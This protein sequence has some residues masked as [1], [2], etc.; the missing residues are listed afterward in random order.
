MPIFRIS[1]LFAVEMIKAAWMELNVECPT[2]C[3]WWRLW[4]QECRRTLSSTHVAIRMWI[5]GNASLERKWLDLISPEMTPL[6]L[7]VMPSHWYVCMFVL[8]VRALG[9][10]RECGQGYDKE[11]DL[12]LVAAN[13][14]AAISYFATLKQLFGIRI[15]VG[16]TW[17]H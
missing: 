10:C 3:L 2:N 7:T 14:L 5:R 1:L 9:S 13:S 16:S 11:D 8:Q 12:L 4:G 6:V 15:T 17:P